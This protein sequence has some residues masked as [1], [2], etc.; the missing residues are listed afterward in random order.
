[1]SDPAPLP[2]PTLPSPATSSPVV[3]PTPSPSTSATSIQLPTLTNPLKKKL[4][5]VLVTIIITLLLGITS[6]FVY[7]YFALKQQIVQAEPSPS[8][9][10]I[11]EDPTVDWETYINT[12]HNISFKYPQSW[13]LSEK[14][15]SQDEGSTAGDPVYNTAIELTKQEV[16][17]KIFL[18]MDGIGGQSQTYEGEKFILDGNN[19]Y[20]YHKINDYNET[21]V[22]GISNTLTTLGVFKLNDIT[23]SISLSYPANY[24]S[25]QESALLSEFDQILSTF[26]FSD[27]S[28]TPSPSTQTLQPPDSQTPIASICTGPAQTPTTMIIIYDNTVDQQP[29]VQVLPNQT[30][31]ITNNSSNSI[32]INTIQYQ[33]TIETGGSYTFPVPLGSF[34]APGVHLLGGTEVWLQ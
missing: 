22:V 6:F 2:D 26:K 19:L 3:P 32:V 9:T 29:C 7:K 24:S 10:T 13:I 30:L 5:P 20:Q 17:I 12:I 4:F 14:E 34:L 21:K 33:T 23:Y 11:T 18:N 1:M 8:P 28:T 25:E 15:G 27:V 31:K 16:L